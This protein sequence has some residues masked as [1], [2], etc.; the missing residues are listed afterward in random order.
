M[1]NLITFGCSLTIDFYQKTWPHY[2]AKKLSYNL[3]NL[4]QRGAGLDYIVKRL[5]QEKIN[6]ENSLVAIMLPSA[7]RFDWFIDLES[8]LQKEAVSIASWQDGKEPYLILPSGEKSLKN[9]YCLSGGQHRGIKKTWFKYFYSEA[10]AELDLW[11]HVLFLQ[12]YLSSCK[13]KY[14][15]TSAYDLDQLIEQ[16]INK[17]KSQN[18][19]FSFI[20][21]LDKTKFIMYKESTGF[22]NFC[23]H[24]Q[25]NFDTADQYPDTTAHLQFVEDVLMPRLSD[26]FF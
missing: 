4:A 18:L 16:K 14:F 19:S 22:L 9:G 3:I 7:D 26:N 6:P 21:K 13:I 20:S 24:K 23:K 15:F 12:L 1:N 5:V 10:K 11:N 8:P 25:L 2:L 17:G